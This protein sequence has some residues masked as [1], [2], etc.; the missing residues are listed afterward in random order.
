MPTMVLRAA[1]SREAVCQRCEEP[2]RAGAGAIRDVR[3][4]IFG[5]VSAG[6]T[7]LLY[8]A[9]DSVAEL[10]ERSG[11]P[12]SYPDAESRQLAER[13]RA[14]IHS[15]A[16][17]AK[18][19]LAAGQALSFRLG[20]GSNSTLVHLFDVAG[21]LYRD[22]DHYEDVSFLDHGHGLIFVVD[23]FGLPSVRN[24]LAGD[25]SVAPQV[26]V[27]AGKDPDLA[28]HQVVSRLRDR[29]VKASSQRLAIVVSKADLL[30]ECGLDLPIAFTEIVEWL[31]DNGLHNVVIAAPNE[32]A[33]V[34]Y[35]A[36][37][38]VAAER[39]TW[40]TDPGAPLRWLLRARGVPLP[41]EPEVVAIGEAGD[42]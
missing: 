9:L 37:A 5:D 10:A 2:L 14:T 39:A 20:D 27:G 40:E 24:R 30:A 33:E 16:D 42:E 8:S 38:S 19:G 12:L 23:P 32:F 6:K 4:P 41:A 7:R 15:A 36:V 11:I 13:A 26:A 29:G 25:A 35:F 31:R 21:E 17:T 22:S 28:Y 18:T 34:R 1:W 3:V